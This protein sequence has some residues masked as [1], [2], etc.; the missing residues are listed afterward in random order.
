MRKTDGMYVL[1]MRDETFGLGK[2]TS[3]D[4]RALFTGI[5]KEHMRNL[6]E[7]NVNSLC[8]YIVWGISLY[9]IHKWRDINVEKEEKGGVD[10]R[11]DLLIWR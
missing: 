5:A 7:M 8:T 3:S 11:K 10:F 9:E 4:T 1:E 6:E 2:W